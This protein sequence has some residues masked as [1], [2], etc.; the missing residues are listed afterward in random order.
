MEKKQG[1]KQGSLGRAK[2]DL[3]IAGT[4]G[5]LVAVVIA[6][7]S[8]AL[9]NIGD[10]EARQLLEAIGPTSQLFCSSILTASA[11]IL[12]LMLAFIGLGTSSDAELA[13]AHY[14]RI[15]KIAL[16]DAIL[17]S[18]ATIMFVLHCIPVYESDALP[19]W[20]YPTIY[21]G[22][23]IA[24]SC[25]AGGA[26]AIVA[27]LYLAVKDVV[28]VVALGMEDHYYAASKSDES[29]ATDSEPEA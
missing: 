7:A 29:A 21:Y 15:V 26:V 28:Q 6:S 22:V 24:S 19:N 2:Q 1:S 13:D 12:A 20:W 8:A 16:Y 25:L 17:F 4:V 18:A 11:T 3:L 14:H 5:A 9:G 23:L 27:L 10:T